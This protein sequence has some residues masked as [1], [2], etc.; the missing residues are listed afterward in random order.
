MPRQYFNNASSTLAANIGTG[1]TTIEVQA[2]HGPRFGTPTVGDPV[3]VTVE[4]GATREIRGATARTGDVLTVT[5]AVEVV[6]PDTV[7]TAYAFTSGADVQVRNTAASYA[8]GGVVLPASSF[9]VFAQMTGWFARGNSSDQLGNIG[10]PNASN[11]GTLTARALSDSTFGSQN[12][13]GFVSAAAINSGAGRFLSSAAYTT[14]TAGNVPPVLLRAAFGISDAVFQSTA[15]MF[16]GFVPNSVVPDPS[17][18]TTSPLIGIGCSPSDTNLSLYHCNGGGTVT[19]VGLGADFPANTTNTDWYDVEL[20][21]EAGSH[22]WTY[23]I[24]NARTGISTSG[25]ATTNVPN[26]SVTHSAQLCRNTLTGTAA[27][28][29]DGAFYVCANG[30]GV[31]F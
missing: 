19:K 23:R 20:R 12:R 2:G 14:A 28:G 4:Q 24:R 8:G 21:R 26:T 7:A 9:G 18:L 5:R 13:L 29:I 15:T 22:S 10:N 11:N 27:V 6:R 17:T 16:V 3:R 1:A 25:S 30:S 31:T